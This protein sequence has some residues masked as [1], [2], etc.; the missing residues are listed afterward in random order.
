MPLLCEVRVSR[1]I[2]RQEGAFQTVA[3]VNHQLE[4]VEV[5]SWNPLSAPNA[6]YTDV[7]TILNNCP[8]HD[9][10]LLFAYLS[11][12]RPD[13]HYGIQVVY[14]GQEG[15]K[16]A[17]IAALVACGSKNKR[18]DVGTAG[19]KIVHTEVKDIANPDGDHRA[20][21]R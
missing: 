15:S 19:H 3:Y 7:L 21:R 14:D 5:A 1:Q 8:E 13:P 10:G 20:A 2:K 9:Q 18:E 16:A 4:S 17:Y 6:S 11:D 12:I